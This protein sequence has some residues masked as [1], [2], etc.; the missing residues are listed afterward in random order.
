LAA[1]RHPIAVLQHPPR[2]AVF[3]ELK[4]GCETPEQALQNEM[5]VGGTGIEPVTSTV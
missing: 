1:Y 2:G 5:V 3:S 4:K